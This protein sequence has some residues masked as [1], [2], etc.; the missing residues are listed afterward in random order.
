MVD[1]TNPPS[2]CG[3]I[4]APSSGGSGEAWE[5][6]Y[7]NVVTRDS[8][9]KVQCD[10]LA[11]FGTYVEALSVVGPQTSLKA[12]R[13]CLCSNVAAT[14]YPSQNMT[15]HS[16]GREARW[17]RP[18]S[19][20]RQPM[21][22]EIRIVRLG[23]DS[24]HLLAQSREPGFMPVLSEP[25]LNKA[26]RSPQYTT[27]FLREW[28][29]WMAE[30]LATCLNPKLRLLDGFQTQSALL[31]ATTPDLDELVGRGLREGEIRIPAKEEAA[32]S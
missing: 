27:P 11:G 16:D 17:C 6:N 13:A 29:P 2:V 15:W 1:R 30:E 31:T 25:A 21:G 19:M 18:A 10:M 24:W 4:L 14:F 26:L 23:Y 5:L 3:R 28:L 7:L 22:Y 20:S 32:S 9:F 8:S 12:L